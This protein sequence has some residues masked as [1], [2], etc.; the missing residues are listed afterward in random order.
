MHPGSGASGNHEPGS[1]GGS[2]AAACAVPGP[3]W[4]GCAG[5]SL[6]SAVQDA[7]P[8]DGTH[9]ER[10]A[11]VLTGVEINSSFYRPHRPATYARWRDSVPDG[12]RFSVK[13]P[14]AITH[15]ARLQPDD[16]TLQR[17]IDEVTH[18]GPKL[19][20]LLAQLPPGLR[21]DAAIAANFLARLRQAA[22][23][24]IACEPR[25]PSWFSDDAMA[26][27]AAHAVSY[28]DADPPVRGQRL[29]ADNGRLCYIRLH[30]SP[31]MYYSRYAEATLQ[32][33]AAE[34]RSAAAAGK[35]V[36]CVFDNTAEGAAVPNALWLLANL[37]QH[38][39]PEQA[40][41]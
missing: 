41:R 38:M 4:I 6:S 36:W 22:A 40:Q 26:L 20:C 29:P 31:V 2:L 39:P 32:T 33:V 10:Y 35:R 17:F 12:F 16:A 8:A 24:D 27:L 28:V 5:W 25:H 34:I 14:K 3:I 37:R 11:R 21:F 30:G 9:L 1:D 13:V 23:V 18:L 19:G 15:E 7:F